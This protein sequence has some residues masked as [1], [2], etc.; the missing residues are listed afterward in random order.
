MVEIKPEE[1]Y[2]LANLELLRRTYG[3]AINRLEEADAETILSLIERVLELDARGCRH[4]YW[5]PQAPPGQGWCPVCGLPIVRRRRN[6]IYCSRRCGA[7][8]RQRRRRERLAYPLWLRGRPHWGE[9]RRPMMDRAQYA[10][11]TLSPPSY[12]KGV[13]PE[14][15]SPLS[16]LPPAR[17]TA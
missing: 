7:T 14:A 12:L 17:G 4:L 15:A 5:V 13:T 2:Q 10:M 9:N 8:A 3:L 16:K 1:F 11:G 6:A